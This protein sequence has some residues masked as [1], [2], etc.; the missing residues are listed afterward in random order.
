MRKRF[1]AKHWLVLAV[2][3]VAIVAVAVCVGVLISAWWRPVVAMAAFVLWGMLLS[4]VNE[5]AYYDYI[6]RSRLD[7]Y[8]RR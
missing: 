1:R 4:A 3:T 5:G 2:G 6:V 8:L 7:R